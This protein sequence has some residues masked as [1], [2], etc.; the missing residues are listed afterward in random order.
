MRRRKSRHCR[1]EVVSRVLLER[2]GMMGLLTCHING[3]AF[4]LPSRKRM[5][6]VRHTFDDTP[7]HKCFSVTLVV[8]AKT[9]LK[10]H[11][12]SILTT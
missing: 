2:G 5:T 10:L 6:S 12:Q 7:I 3:R 4:R 9:E 11:A 8:L 1:D